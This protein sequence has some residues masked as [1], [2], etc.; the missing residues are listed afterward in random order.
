MASTKNQGQGDNHGANASVNVQVHDGSGDVVSVKVHDGSSGDDISV[1]VH[2][3]SG[4]NVSVTVHDGSGDNVSVQV[5]D[6][7]GDVVSVKVQDGPSGDDIS[8]KVHDGSGDD[9]SVKVHDGSGGVSVQ[10]DDGSGGDAPCY[11]RGTSILTQRG[12]VSVEDLAIGDPVMTISGEAKPIKWI[13]R[14]SYAGRFIA[15]NPEVWPIVVRAGALAPEIPVRDLWL[16]PG[17][18]LLLDGV[19]VPAE[20]LVNA[21]TVVRADA[22]DRVEYFH[23]EFEAHE[24]ILAEGA[25]AESYVECDNRRGFHNADEFT[26]LYLDDARASFGYCLPRLQAGMAELAAIRARLFERAAALGH[27]TTADPDLHLVVD[28]TA[29]AAQS[30]AE[31]RHVFHARCAGGGGLARR[32]A[33]ASRPNWN[34]CRATGVASA[35]ASSGSCLRDDHLR[36]EI[37]HSHPALCEGFHEDEEGVR[38]WT[39]GM[40][41]VPEQF[42]A[43]LY[44]RV[45]HRGALPAATAGLFAAPADC[46][47]PGAG[48]PP[49][50]LRG[51][52]HGRIPAPRRSRQPA[53]AKSRAA[54]SGRRDGRPPLPYSSSTPRR[55]PWCFRYGLRGRGVQLAPCGHCDP[56]CWTAG[57]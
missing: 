22:V 1:K 24:V 42:P 15:G 13:G 3:G 55:R 30:V 5:H 17:H 44:R 39:T 14:R 27:S 8:V 57:K 11:C 21:L 26:A 52:R 43:R 36:V 2:D 50:R 28:G 34:C 6:G 18:A 56:R 31:D 46:S 53:I 9:I 29:V 10:V 47:A 25:P 19:L 37:A 16:S 49:R 32:P 35:S 41:R 33:A 20:H 45:Q 4:D 54:A 38:R 40:G 7:S 48:H 23:L 51:R 12:E